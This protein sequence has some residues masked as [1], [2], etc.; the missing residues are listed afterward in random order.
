[1]ELATQA[2]SQAIIYEI[3]I[4]STGEDSVLLRRQPE[5]KRRSSR[6][7]S[8]DPKSWCDGSAYIPEMGF[9][10]EFRRHW[11]GQQT[12]RPGITVG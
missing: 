12:Q 5:G 7:S 10:A 1:M 9:Y 6:A 3:G 2:E 11:N 4:V 8:F